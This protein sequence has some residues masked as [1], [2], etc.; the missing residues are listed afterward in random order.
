MNF[1]G[2]P[3]SI[4]TRLRLSRFPAK[5]IPTIS[6]SVPSAFRAIDS[7]SGGNVL[8]FSGYGIAESQGL[9][10]SWLPLEMKTGIPARAASS[11]K[12]LRSEGSEPFSN[13]S[14]DMTMK[15]AF[16]ETAR[17][18]ILLNDSAGAFLILSISPA[19]PVR[20]PLKREPRWMSAQWMNL[21]SPMTDPISA[22]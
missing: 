12:N 4:E 3:A 19:S 10:A 13:M 7:P 6:I 17:S 21:K 20:T 11:Q 15:E 18:T 9:S 8:T 16:S 1:P 2:V 5:L 14:P 22:R